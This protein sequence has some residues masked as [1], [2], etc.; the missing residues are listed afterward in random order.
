MIDYIS[1]NTEVI[2]RA[3]SE[4]VFLALIPVLLAIVISLPLG[5]LAVRYS[6]LYYPLV[7]VSSILYAIPSLALFLL[8]PPIIGTRVLSPL[9]IIIALTIYSVALM[10]RVVADGL[11]SV[12]PTVTQAA[13]AMGYRRIKRLFSVELPIALPVMLA[14][15][16]VATVANVSIVSV[17]ALL[18]VGGLGA[19]FLRGLQLDYLDPIIVGIVLSVLLAAVCDSVI[20][21]VQRRFTPWSRVGGRA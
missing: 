17:G 11:N 7:N 20:V 15:L 4:H 9:N 1:S 14:G 6:K 5:Y 13:T 10:V 8:L 12:D 3:F 21:L 16:R 2:W 19:L 18:G